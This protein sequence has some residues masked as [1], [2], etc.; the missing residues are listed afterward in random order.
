MILLVSFVIS[1]LK[2]GWKSEVDYFLIHGHKSTILFRISDVQF[3]IFCTFYLNHDLPDYTLCHCE[4]SAA[5]ADYAKFAI[6]ASQPR[7]GRLLLA[8][9]FQS[10]SEL[11]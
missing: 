2:T 9:T 1:S 4:R 8:M 7:I 6:A 5:I 3:R 11:A 10:Y